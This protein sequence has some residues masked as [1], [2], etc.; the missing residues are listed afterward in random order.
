MRSAQYQVA[1]DR[2]ARILRES[3]LDLCAAVHDSDVS[4]DILKE[5]ADFERERRFESDGS[6]DM[7]TQNDAS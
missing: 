3:A 2:I 6:G 1:P 5:A 7:A 4:S